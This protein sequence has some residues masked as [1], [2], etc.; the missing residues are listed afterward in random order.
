MKLRPWIMAAALALALTACGNNRTD[1][2]TVTTPNNTNSPVDTTLPATQAPSNGEVTDRVE[3]TTPGTHPVENAGNGVIDAVEDAGT[4]VAEG[5]KDIINGAENAVND[6]GNGAKDV[7][8]GTGNAV[9][10]AGNT[11]RRTTTD[12][13]G[14]TNAARRSAQ[15]GA[16]SGKTVRP[17]R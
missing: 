17:S 1:G 10:N 11:A 3:T 7:I 2:T 8:D 16:T 4:G 13:N 12:T 15:S 9:N 5:A 6:V 14:R